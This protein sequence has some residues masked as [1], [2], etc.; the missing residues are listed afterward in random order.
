MIVNGY[1]VFNLPR[2]SVALNMNIW[3]PSLFLKK[4]PELA[5]LEQEDS[6]HR[7]AFVI[8]NSADAILLVQ[9][10]FLVETVTWVAFPGRSI[11]NENL[12][13]CP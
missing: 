5:V 13:S 7:E 4:V 9:Y 3:R 2:G 10:C 1:L 11:A 12:R 6:R 8:T